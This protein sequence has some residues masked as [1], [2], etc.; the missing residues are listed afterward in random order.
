[1][2]WP[3]EERPRGVLLWSNHPKMGKNPD[4]CLNQAKI[5]LKSFKFALTFGTTLRAPWFF[6]LF[7]VIL[8]VFGLGGGGG[9]GVEG[10]AYKFHANLRFLMLG[11]IN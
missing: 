5:G 4:F 9:W 2:E 11:I 1:M 3:L 8:H 6:N 7:W 10:A